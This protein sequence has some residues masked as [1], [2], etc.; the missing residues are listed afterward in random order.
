MV[1]GVAVLGGFDG[2]EIVGRVGGAAEVALAVGDAEEGGNVGWVGVCE[3]GG[4]EGVSGSAGWA[5]G[6][7]D[8]V[9]VGLAGVAAVG[10]EG[11]GEVHE[12]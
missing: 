3:G 10:L 12:G 8:E 7:G 6:G 4:D 11:G 9:W 5:G 2:G 1:G